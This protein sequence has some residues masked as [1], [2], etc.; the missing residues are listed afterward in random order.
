MSL[1]SFSLL[2]FFPLY[3][4]FPT[5]PIP[6]HSKHKFIAFVNTV[7]ASPRYA[8]IPMKAID[9]AS[10]TNCTASFCLV[11]LNVILSIYIP[12]C[13]I[14][15]LID[16]TNYNINDVKFLLRKKVFYNKLFIKHLC[17]HI[18]KPKV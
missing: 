18:I 5:Y 8:P 7:L 3:S 10:N 1:F 13:F 14:T 9:T 17:N 15:C 2:L 6:T 11:D 4:P 16:E 12:P